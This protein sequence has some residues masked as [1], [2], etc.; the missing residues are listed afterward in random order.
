ML[1]LSKMGQLDRLAMNYR[2]M[3]Q[4]L[5]QAQ[6][7]RSEAY[8]LMFR[9]FFQVPSEQEHVNKYYEYLFRNFR[10][11]DLQTRYPDLAK[12]W[13]PMKNGFLTAWR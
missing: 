2:V 11:N 7:C 1:M 5:L 4:E 8:N 13:H 10:V 3:K 6:R 12:E 9:A